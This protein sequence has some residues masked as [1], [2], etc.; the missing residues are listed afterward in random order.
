[1]NIDP[2]LTYQEAVLDQI[3]DRFY[4]S[5]YGKLNWNQRM[6]GISGLRGVGKTT[7]LLQ[8]LKYKVENRKNALYVTADHPWFYENSLYD[9][10][11]QFT[12]YGGKLLLV[13]EIHK[14]PRWSQTLKNCYDA[15]PDLQIVFTASS[16]LDML[17][18]EADLSRR[19]L[20]F[21]LPGLS[22][23]EYLSLFHRINLAPLT[24]D[25][26]LDDPAYHAS[27][28]LHRIKPLPL[29]RSY[30]REG[31]FPFYLQEEM[32]PFQS[33]LL[34]VINTILESDLPLIMRYSADHVFKIK[35]LLGVIVESVPFEP[36]I[37]KLARKMNIGRDT[38]K[39]YL[40][41]LS[42]ARLLNLLNKSTKGV[43]NLQKPDKIYLENTN[44]SYGLK[45]TPE[46]GTIRES[47]FLNQVKNAGYSVSLAHKG[48]FLIED[49]HTFE[50]GGLNKDPEQIKNLQNAWLVLDEMEHAFHNRIPLWLF[51]FLY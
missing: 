45:A 44:F 40:V 47:F 38:V 5:L 41:N 6:F 46:I 2:L 24:L 7:L 35:K 51:G 17:K 23:R 16:M 30:L 29:F 26:L 14:Y 15:F 13:D 12:K 37:S 22:F 50:I 27:E 19:A 28:I 9:L 49:K 43:A 21:E 33:K 4:R 48:D 25:Q 39:E 10:S 3:D 42:K 34:Q 31:Y 20:N 8:H 18:G 11:S 32:E 36:N 1:M